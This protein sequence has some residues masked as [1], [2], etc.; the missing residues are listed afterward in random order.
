MHVTL[1]V[2]DH[3]WNLRSRRCFGVIGPAL[4]RAN[5]RGDL[6]V[7]CFSV[8]GNHVHLVVE[9]SDAVALAR[10]MKGLGVRI[11]RGLNRLMGRDG[12]VFADHY[13]EHVLRTPAEVRRALGYVLGNFAGHAGRRGERVDPAWTD[14]FSSVAS[15]ADVVSPRTWLLRMAGVGHAGT[16]PSS[17][18]TSTGAVR[19]FTDRR[20]SSL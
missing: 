5:E 11:A 20:P 10:G 2:R 13:H 15:P 18:K 16:G 7:V 9:S 19:P 4:S 6:R 12:P 3:V 17:S 1:R 14:P 8:Q